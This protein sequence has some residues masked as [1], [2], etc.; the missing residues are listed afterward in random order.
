MDVSPQTYNASFFVNAVNNTYLANQT[1]EF[2]LALKSNLTGETYATGT[3]GPVAVDT[4]RFSQLNG[5]IVN[6]QTAGDANNTF[7]ITFDAEELRGQTLYFALFSLFP[8]TFKS[9]CQ[10]FT[11]KLAPPRTDFS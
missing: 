7:S 9:E 4:F 2:T 3:I 10:R 8:E 11:T 6:N 1:T 5:T